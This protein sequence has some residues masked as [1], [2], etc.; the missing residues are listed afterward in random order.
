MKRLFAATAIILAASSARAGGDEKLIDTDITCA[1]SAF[2]VASQVQ[3]NSP[4]WYS[5]LITYSFF[6]GRLTGRN[7][8]IDWMKVVFDRVAAARNNPNLVKL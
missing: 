8:Q 7:E 1:V 6:V 3:R 2:A 5:L 4:E